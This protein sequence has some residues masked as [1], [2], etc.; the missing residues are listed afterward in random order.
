M[1]IARYVIPAAAGIA[2]IVVSLTPG[3]SGPFAPEAAA[4]NRVLSSSPLYVDN[5]KS[6][7]TCNV[8][9]VSN[10]AVTLK[11]DI[12]NAAGTVLAS[13]GAPGFSLAAS[14]IYELPAFNYSGY[15][16]CR[17]HMAGNPANIRANFLVLHYSGSYW[18]SLA[19]SELH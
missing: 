2:L 3:A 5:G 6:S 14:H 12:V 11:V 1:S 8:A 16:F 7:H 9:N 4:L 19:M 13:S 10:V 17:I 18:E 15:A